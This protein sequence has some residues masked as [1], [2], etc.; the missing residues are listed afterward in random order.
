[1]VLNLRSHAEIR[2]LFNA[3][4]AQLERTVRAEW[5]SGRLAHELRSAAATGKGSG[6]P[7]ARCAGADVNT[8]LRHARDGSIR[9]DRAATLAFYVDI[10]RPRDV[11]EV[12]G[13]IGLSS[14]FLL[15]L[16]EPWNGTL[17]SIDP[18]YPHRCFIE[19]RRL[20]H[21]M[22]PPA[23]GRVH[24]INAFWRV[25]RKLTA[26]G[27]EE[28]WKQGHSVSPTYFVKRGKRFDM[29]FI[30]GCHDYDTVIAD[31]HALR[32]L[33]RRHACVA[34]DDVDAKAWP[35]TYSALQDL[36]REFAQNGLGTVLVGDQMALFLDQG[37]FGRE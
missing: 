34:F 21:R 10:C 4:W 28:P 36:K 19:P 6:A 27:L 37:H 13:Y 3:S 9:F 30:D 2:T 22:N 1:M 15:R 24:T 5:D 7:T 16:M 17:W 25:A 18:N 12:G 33:M 23:S 11:V 8:F 31:F 35:A 14:N 20:Y 26:H 32:P 29:A